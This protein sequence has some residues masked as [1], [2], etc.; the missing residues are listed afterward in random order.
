MWAFAYTCFFCSFVCFC[1]IVLYESNLFGPMTEAPRKIDG[2]GKPSYF[3]ASWRHAQ[4][5]SFTNCIKGNVG[6]NRNN[7]LT[8]AKP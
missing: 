6:S 4:K 3:E 7:D 8:N 5:I 1:S 2:N